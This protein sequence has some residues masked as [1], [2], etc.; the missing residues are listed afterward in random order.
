MENPSFADDMQR[1]FGLLRR[2]AWLLIL[3]TLLAG[4]AAYLVSK[5]ITPVYQAVTTV[6]I[7]EAPATK[8][9]DYSAIMTSERLAQTYSQLMTKQPVLEGVMARLGLDLDIEDLKTAI[10]VQ[11]V[12][13]TTLIEVRVDDTDPARAADIANTLVVEFADRNQA[14]QTSRYA[15]SKDSLSAQLDEMNAQIETTTN[16]VAELAAGAETQTERDRLEANLAQYRQTYAY[17]LQSYEQVRLAEAQSTSNVIQ[18][19]PATAPERPIRPRAFTNTL[20]AMVVGLMFAAG[21]V[22]LI[23]AMDDTL[24][25]PDQ[26]TGQLGLPVLGLVVRHNITEGKPVTMTEPRSQVAEA[27]RRAAHEYPICQRR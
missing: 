24:K 5:R 23:E 13:D 19:E 1:Y 25:G 8:S 11:P 6:L 12:R 26:V 17:L 4:A 2:W 27:F 16:Q 10:Q 14:L 22:F 21:L 18:A 3:A 7:N 9:A 15:A 20:L